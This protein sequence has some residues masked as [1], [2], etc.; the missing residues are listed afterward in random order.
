MEDSFKNTPFFFSFFSVKVD[1]KV[2]SR[3]FLEEYQILE[4]LWGGILYNCRVGFG[5]GSN[6]VIPQYSRN[7]APRRS[8]LASCYKVS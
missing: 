6:I 3:S 1:V 4:E 2:D 8:H 5:V 7:T